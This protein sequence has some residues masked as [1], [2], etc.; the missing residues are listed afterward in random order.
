MDFLEFVEEVFLR[1]VL[2]IPDG[3][4]IGQNREDTCI[5]HHSHMGLVH[6]ADSVTEHLKTGGDRDTS[7]RHGFDVLFV[8][9]FRVEENA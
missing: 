9:E 7:G 8:A 1:F 5:I 3:A 4:G 2:V 6:A